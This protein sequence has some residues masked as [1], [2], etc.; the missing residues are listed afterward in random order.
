MYLRIV[1][2]FCE[3]GDVHSLVNFELRF[4]MLV[5]ISRHNTHDLD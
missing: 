3:N 2:S 1:S 4:R 5:L